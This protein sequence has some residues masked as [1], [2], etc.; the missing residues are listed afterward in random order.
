MIAKKPFLTIMVY[1]QHFCLVNYV[2]RIFIV[3]HYQLK[4]YSNK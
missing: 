2:F 3:E 1:F 4:R